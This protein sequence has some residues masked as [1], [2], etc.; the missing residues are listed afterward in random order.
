MRRFLLLPLLLIALTTRTPSNA[1]A[2]EAAKWPLSLRDGLPASLPGWASNP[3]DPLPDEDENAMGRYTEV[4]RFFQKIES[5]TSAKQFRVTVQDYGA[6]KDLAPQLKKAFSDAAASGV[7]TRSVEIAGHRAY[8]VTDRSSGRPTTIVT[9]IVSPSRLVLGEGANVA[10]EEA[11]ALI[12][13][14]DFPRV[15]GAR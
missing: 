12:R 14:V 3:S 6:G 1:C 5:S 8:S 9:V 15:A 4:A 7:E 11:L 10:A 2:A 13:A